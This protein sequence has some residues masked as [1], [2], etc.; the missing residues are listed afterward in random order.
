M[1]TANSTACSSNRRDVAD[2]KQRARILRDFEAR[3]LTEAYNVPLLWWQRIVVMDAQVRDG[4]CP[5]R[6][7]WIGQ[8]LRACVAGP[9]ASQLHRMPADPFTASSS[10]QANVKLGS[11][12]KRYAPTSCRCAFSTLDLLRDGVNIAETALK[13]TGEQIW[14]SLHATI[15]RRVGDR[16]PPRECA[17]VAA[18]RI[19]MRCEMVSSPD[20]TTASQARC[21]VVST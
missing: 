1:S 17:K 14:R 20:A 8:D 5:L 9:C 4:R 3:M 13:R 15:P 21:A 7:T 18:I 10:P 11:K 6:A 2:P 19:S 16:L 12:P